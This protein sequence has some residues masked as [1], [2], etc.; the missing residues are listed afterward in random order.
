MVAHTAA[1][2][3]GLWNTGH[4]RPDPRLQ[5]HPTDEQG[6]NIEYQGAHLLLTQDREFEREDSRFCLF[7]G[8]PVSF[9][10]ARAWTSG[11]KDA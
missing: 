2:C 5:H 1:R 7:A 4:H 8:P 9:E 6:K 10:R 11:S 3:R